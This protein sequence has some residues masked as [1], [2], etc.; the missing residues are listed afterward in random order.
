MKLNKITH[1]SIEIGGH[2]DSLKATLRNPEIQSI[3][4]LEFWIII[5]YTLYYTYEQT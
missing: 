5:Q 4:L 2:I 3:I 1:T